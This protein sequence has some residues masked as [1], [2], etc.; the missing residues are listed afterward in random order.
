MII[1]IS[2]TIGA[3]KGT[4]CEYLKKKGFTYFSLSDFLRE[5]LSTKGK[6]HTRDNLRDLGDSIRAEKGYFELARLVSEKIDGISKPRKIVV[7][8]IRHTS[9]VEFFRKRYGKEFR[10]VFIDALI[11]LRYERILIRKKARD[12]ISFDEFKRQEE[13]EMTTDGPNLQIGLCRNI[14]DLE[15]IND[16][17]AEELYRK[18]EELIGRSP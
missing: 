15:I 11:K 6:E 7:D 16:S 12:Y 13:L 4:A 17:T 14:A 1:G 18:I 3:G 5:M 8:S 9:E 10:L 2:G